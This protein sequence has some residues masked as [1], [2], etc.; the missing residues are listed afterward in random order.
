M[1]VTSSSV[2]EQSCNMIIETQ[3]LSKTYRMGSV[4]VNALR[5]VNVQVSEGEFV[6]LMGPSGS[7][8]STLMHLLGCLDTPTSGRYLLQGRDVSKLSKDE[9]A[10]TRNAHIGFVFQTFNLLPRL[11]ALDNVTLPLMYSNAHNVRQRAAQALER[12]GLSH[13]AGHQP[14]EMSGGERQRVA[15]A[16]ALVTDPALI[17]ADEPTGNLDSKTGTEIM[18]LLME[19]HRDGHTILMVTH[20]PTVAANAERIIRMQD[21]ELTKDE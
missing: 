11:G 21:G 1:T 17:L 2:V 4:Q 15:I 7:G 18:R 20:D 3:A 10:R 14:N 12:V 16:R 5:G 6:A 9:R 8:K 13:R 19:L